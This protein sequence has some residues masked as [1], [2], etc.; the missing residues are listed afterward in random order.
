MIQ[1]AA[2]VDVVFRADANERTGTGHVM[3][4][5]ALAGQIREYGGACTF[6]CRKEGLGGI[7]ELIVEAGHRL[8][9]WGD[10]PNDAARSE[11]EPDGWGWLPGGWEMDVHQCLH[12]LRELDRP[13]WIVVDHYGI[14]ARW[15]VAMRR[16]ARKLLAVDDVA[17]RPHECDVLLDQ[18]LVRGMQHRYDALVPAGTQTLLGPHY[19]LLRPEFASINGQRGRPAQP[20]RLLVMLGG[21]D[22]H[23]LTARMMR[24]ISGLQWGGA[25]DVVVGPLYANLEKL[26]K[27]M[28]H[29]RE[30][31]IHAP[32]WNIAELMCQAD[33]ALGSPGVTSWERCA[34]A[35]RHWQPSTF[36]TCFRPRWYSS[37][38]QLASAS[39]NR[40]SSSISR[41]L[42]AQC[43]A[44]PSLEMIRNT[45]TM[46]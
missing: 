28:R 33:L 43:S 9:T 45:F 16:S 3:R 46:P 22:P 1:V 29:L 12:F 21:A 23:D 24:I 7:G 15:E 42:V 14:D 35:L 27:T 44:V 40:P 6:L 31:K 39:F 5:L 13:D 26:R 8:F 20:P 19:A 32:A 41:S 11:S 18:N 4:C 38:F 17:D 10:S 25:V 34:C 36:V 2:A 30:G 37:I